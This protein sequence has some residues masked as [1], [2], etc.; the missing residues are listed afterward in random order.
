[1]D[2]P[3]SEPVQRWRPVYEDNPPRRAAGPPFYVRSTHHSEKERGEWRGIRGIV[4][5]MTAYSRG[6]R[7]P[8][9][10]YLHRL[11]HVQVTCLIEDRDGDSTLR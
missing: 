6:T 11:Q 9:D 3:E 8:D 4:S 2:S 5:V 10:A 1:M 7:A